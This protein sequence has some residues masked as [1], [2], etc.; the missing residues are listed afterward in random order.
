[1]YEILIASCATQISRISRNIKQKLSRK[2]DILAI[3]K[4]INFFHQIL[5]LMYWEF[6]KE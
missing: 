4:Y 5:K 2:R 3:K 6:L 1:M